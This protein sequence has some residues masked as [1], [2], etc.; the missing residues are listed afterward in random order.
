VGNIMRDCGG[1]DIPCHRVVAAGG[2][3][4]GYGGNVAMKRALLRAEGLQ[5]GVS[6]IRGFADC[7]WTGRPGG[8]APAP[9]RRRPSR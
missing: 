9:A 6:T 2:R 1:R 7:R 3:L 4:G 8:K 5:V